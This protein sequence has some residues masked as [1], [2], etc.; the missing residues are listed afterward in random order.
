MKKISSSKSVKPK[1]NLSQTMRV[2]VP[3]KEGDKSVED[4]TRPDTISTRNYGSEKENKKQ[5]EEEDCSAADD[6]LNEGIPRVS[7][8]Y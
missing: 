3:I 6:E 1:I 4:N 8:M 2:S 7:P 5:E